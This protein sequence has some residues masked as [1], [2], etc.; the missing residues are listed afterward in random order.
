MIEEIPQPQIR[1]PKIMIYCI[2]IGMVSGFIFLSCLLF[3]VKNIYNVIGSPYGPL[4][5]IFLGA[6]KSRAGSVCLLMFPLI[7]VAFAAISIMCTSS[8]M[9]YA[10]ARDRGMPFSHVF[11]KVHPE[12]HVPLNALMWTTGWVILFGC[13]FLGSNS[14][15]NAI[16]SAA[17]VA[18]GITYAIPPGINVL[19]GRKMLPEDRSFKIPEPFGWILN[20]VRCHVFY[21]FLF[22]P[23]VIPLYMLTP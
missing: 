15:F 11:A 22:L 18:L 16:S 3:C 5:Q 14:T 10:F 7:C 4:L 21:S 6:T 12:L 23:R 1:G 13:I 9:S 17:V 8:R 19:R 20:I 2:A